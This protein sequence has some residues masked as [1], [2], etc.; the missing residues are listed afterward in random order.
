MNSKPLLTV[1]NLSL[2]DSKRTLFQE[3]NFDVSQGEVLAI[4][5]PS[6]IGK[7]MLSKAIA[8]FL[9]SDVMVDGSV[10]LNDS[11]VGQLPMLQRSQTQRPAVIFQDALKALNPLATVEQQ[12]SL[13]LT[14][15]KTRLNATNRDA[16]TELLAQLGLAEPDSILALYPSQLSGGQRQRI[17]IAI[18]LLGSANL[19]IADEP[20]SALDPI[21]ENEILNLF[22][23]SIQQRCIGG[24]LIT[25]DLSAAL[26]CDKLLVIADSTMVAYGEPTQAIRQSQHPFCQQLE[27]LLS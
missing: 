12:L 16:V 19:V 5:G 14:V 24:I 4:M 25:H 23:N 17:C 13:A 8:G 9:P 27:Q 21:T 26:A 20:T 22:R 15:N 11:E 1:T 3:I 7:S 2:A 10:Q 18:S 6:G